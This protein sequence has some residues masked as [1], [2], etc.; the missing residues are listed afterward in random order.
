M[1]SIDCHHP[2]LE[3]FIDIKT[4]LNRVTKANISVR[5]TE[6]CMKAV[7]NNEMFNLE[8]FREETGETISKTVNAREIFYKLAK[9]N[10][11]MGEPG[12]LFWDRIENWNLLS[13]YDNFE[14]AGTNPCTPNAQGITVM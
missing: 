8:F 1:I 3:E 2:D 9:N 12:V 7:K 4:D 11:D 13:E 5:I 10:W 14:Y 6:D